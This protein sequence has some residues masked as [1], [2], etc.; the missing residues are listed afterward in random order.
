MT[1]TSCACHGD[2]KR[3]ERDPAYRT[4]LMIVVALNL[5][6]GVIELIGGFL[7]SSQALKADS[8][9]FLGDGSISLLGLL[10]LAWTARARAR[11]AL[12]QG[13]FLGLLGL[14][15][16]GFA[17]WRAFHASL[18]EAGLMG[19][20]G[21]VALV[22]NVASALILSRF[23][24]GDANVRAIWLFSRNDAIANVA[25]IIAAGLVAWTGRGWP[26]LAVAAVI[27]LLFLHS[28]YAIV[29]DA[30]GELRNQRGEAVA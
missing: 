24:E 14:G 26:D 22:I 9:D 16:I 6:F 10:A 17:I 12:S 4:A 1:E 2:T 18:P 23:R 11:V 27:A 30:W 28:A 29:G 21:A 3:A 20:I 7:A 8:L 5:G 19:G 15:V 25:V 13:T